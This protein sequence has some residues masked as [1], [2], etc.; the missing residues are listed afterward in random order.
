M[1]RNAYFTYLGMLQASYAMAHKEFHLQ[2]AWGQI[3]TG[4]E[5]HTILGPQGQKPPSQNL[6]RAPDYP[7]VEDVIVGTILSIWGREAIGVL[8]PKP[9]TKPV[10]LY[11]KCD[12]PLCLNNGL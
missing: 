11:P 7:Q 2:C 1:T 12:W 5:Y 3:L 4:P 6:K 8:T 10:W 9:S